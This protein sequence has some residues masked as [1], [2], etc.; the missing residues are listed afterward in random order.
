MILQKISRWGQPLKRIVID[1]AEVSKDLAVDAKTKPVKYAFW[2][3]LGGILTTFYT[4]CPDLKSYRK[5]II[6]YSNELGLCAESAR[7]NKTKAYID[8]VSNSLDND[9]MV[10]WNLGICALII[11]QSHSLS[12]KNYL[13]ICGYLQPRLWTFHRRLID[14]GIWNQWITLNRVMIDFD[15][16][17]DEF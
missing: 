12:C 6:D 17:E 14:I 16:N 7:N 1:Y 15:V 2:L 10:Y 4:R 9:C 5:E 11:Q 8:E 3:I 13:E